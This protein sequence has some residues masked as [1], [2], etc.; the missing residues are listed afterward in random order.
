MRSY[1]IPEP[2]DRGCGC[3]P[4]NGCTQSGGC[5]QSGGCSQSAGRSPSDE[6]TQRENNSC[7]EFV[8]AM[9]YVPWQYFN[10]VYDPDKALQA[11]TIFPELD[12][13]FFGGRGMTRR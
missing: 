9:A 7:S 2:A 10:T 1:R 12:K 8:I 6:R 3:M 13:P 5:A 4:S 11:G